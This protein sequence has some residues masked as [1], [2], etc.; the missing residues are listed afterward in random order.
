[1]LT[2]PSLASAIRDGP[3]R[4]S[5]PGP[6]ALPW[7]RGGQRAMPGHGR[8]RRRGGG[9]LEGSLPWDIPSCPPGG[10]RPPPQVRQYVPHQR[11][12]PADPLRRPLQGVLFELVESPPQA[13]DEPHLGFADLPGRPLTRVPVPS[14]GRDGNNPRHRLPGGPRYRGGAAAEGVA[15]QAPRRGVRSPAVPRRRYWDT[16]ASPC[17]TA[18]TARGRVGSLARPAAGPCRCRGGTRSQTESRTRRPA[19]PRSERCAVRRRAG[20]G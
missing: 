10:G 11:L 2:V 5:R 14:P 8:R 1:L 18:T 12:V 4:E 16:R 6:P 17:W 20:C 3:T 9:R 7:G 15:G 13:V 19:P